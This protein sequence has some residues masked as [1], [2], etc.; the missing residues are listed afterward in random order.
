MLREMVQF[1][2]QRLMELDVEGRGGA[3]YDEKSFGGCFESTPTERAGIPARRLQPRSSR[4]GKAISSILR[5]RCRFSAWDWH[6]SAG[7]RPEAVVRMQTKMEQTMPSEQ[8]SAS[9]AVLRSAHALIS[10]EVAF[11]D[12]VRKLASLRFQ[13]SGVD[14]DPDFMLFVAVDSQ[15]DHIPNDGVRQL[16]SQAWLDQCDKDARELEA[17]YGAE[18]RAACHTL[19]DRFGTGA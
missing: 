7:D 19:T 8:P 17:I 9:F 6:P 1:M 18:I 11:L 12:G 13:A 2:P 3:G 15:A 4:P 10:G 14:Q 5:T 16:C